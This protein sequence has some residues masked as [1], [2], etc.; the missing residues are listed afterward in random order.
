MREGVM[1]LRRWL[2]DL[3]DVELMRL[4][5]R[6]EREIKRRGVGR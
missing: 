6:V 5:E 2:A 3:S 1:E 4:R